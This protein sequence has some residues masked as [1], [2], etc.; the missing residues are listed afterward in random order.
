MRK[1]LHALTHRPITSAEDLWRKMAVIG[2]INEFF[3]W[4]VISADNHSYTLPFLANPFRSKAEMDK[5]KDLETLE[6]EYFDERSRTEADR[7]FD[8]IWSMIEPRLN[9]NWVLLDVGCNTGYF[10]QKFYEKGFTKLYGIDPHAKAVRYAH[11]HRPHLNVKEAFFGPPENDVECDVLVFFKSIYRIPYRSRVFDAIDRCAKKYVVLEGVPE[12]TTFNRDVHVGL[13]KKGF[14]CIE[15]R[16][17]DLEFI[18]IGHKGARGP[19]IMQ[20]GPPGNPKL[21]RNFFSN[22]VFRRVEPRD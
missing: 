21:E 22:Y 15:K 9:K 7:R 18:P 16:V 8:F 19:L 5:W 11:E 14:M 6:Y 4:L 17:T 20:E 2:E 10:L 3:K 13:S 12:M 1:L